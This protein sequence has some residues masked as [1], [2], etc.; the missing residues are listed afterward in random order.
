M[1]KT[2]VALTPKLGGRLLE[3]LN[4]ESSDKRRS[5]ALE[6]A[7]C[8]KGVPRFATA[9]Y[10]AY[11]DSEQFLVVQPGPSGDLRPHVDYL[12]SGVIY[13]CYS[14]AGRKSQCGGPFRTR[15]DRISR[16]SRRATGEM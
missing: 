7:P 6:R 1:H 4:G 2:P 10:G 12:G 9:L 15:I 16:Y 3:V 13:V 8:L 14:R 5:N 11:E